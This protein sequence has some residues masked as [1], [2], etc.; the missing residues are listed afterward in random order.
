MHILISRIWNIE[1]FNHEESTLIYSEQRQNIF[2]WLNKQT[3][4]TFFHERNFNIFKL[5]SVELKNY[6]DKVG[7][8]WDLWLIYNST[9]TISSLHIGLEICYVN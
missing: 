2:N 7:V 9:Q 3:R 4:I 1:Q 5:G 8:F 6:K